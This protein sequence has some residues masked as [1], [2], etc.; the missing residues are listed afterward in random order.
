MSFIIAS[1]TALPSYKY[2]QLQLAQFM[3]DL[4]GLEAEEKRKLEILYERSG[5]KSRYSVLKD[6]GLNINERTFFPNTRNLEP[7]PSLE[8]RMDVFLKE[9]HLLAKQ[10]IDEAIKGNCSVKEITHLITVSCTGLSAPGLD[11][12][13]VQSM[14]F[15]SDI[16]RTSVNF[17]GC[18]AAIH[19]LKMADYICKSNSNAK[20]LV[21]CVELCTLHFQKTQDKDNIAANLLFA[22]GAAAVLIQ[23][24]N[25]NGLKIEGFSSEL[26]L[27]GKA[28]MAWHLSSK[29]FLMTLSAYIPQ[30]IEKG[31]E[32]LVNKALQKL[33]LQKSNIDYWAIH[34]GGRK[35]L[36][37]I[38][39]DLKLNNKQIEDSFH[40]LSQYGN[41]SSP[42]VL[43]VL[44]EIIQKIKPEERIF[45]AAFGPGLTIE[46]MSLI[47][48]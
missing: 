43:F 17:M 2:S 34:P 48:S 9:A 8:Q 32:P 30:L 29:G 24:I 45:S 15:S 46:T 16:E 12:Q 10:A 20:V 39:Q 33:Q 7:F 11:I 27:E 1:G 13:L 28:D 6:F 40:V 21:V 3:T 47:R 4:H 25:K 14:N 19:A 41:M 42:T 5:I 35:I 23:S 26:A 44:K 31:F 18:Y 22:D 36:E 37:V 38:Q